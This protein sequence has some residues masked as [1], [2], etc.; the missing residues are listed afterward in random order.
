GAL[1][2]IDWSTVLLVGGIITYVCVLQEIGSVDLLGDLAAS[3]TVPL[4]AALVICA[5]CGLVSAF[6]ST[7]GILAALVPLAIPL[8]QQGGIPGWALIC[9]LGV[10]LV[11]RGRVSLLD[12]G[13][14]AGRH[15]PVDEQER[16]R[17]TALL[18]R[19]GLSM[20]VIARLALVG[21]LC[22]AGHGRVRR[23]SSCSSPP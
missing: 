21:A 2:E 17:M 1:K 6:A 3:L 20:V 22:T 9:A 10:L 16:P 12:G 8:V 14:D 5:V 4:L 23:R 18:T 19:W 15:P 11:H 13:C 7:T